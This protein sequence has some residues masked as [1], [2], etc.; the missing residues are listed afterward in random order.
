[1][2]L[3]WYFQFSM[4]QWYYAR[5]GERQGPVDR[6]TLESLARS[7]GLSADDLVWAEGMGDWQPA[8]M[9]DGLF[10]VVA[11]ADPA[12]PYASPASMSVGETGPRAPVG[13]L[14]VL[15]P[16]GRVNVG[17]P[18]QLA[19][20]IL[21]KDFGMIFVA[22]LVYYA[23][24]MGM[25]FLFQM[26]QSVIQFAT[27]GTM[28]SQ[29]PTDGMEAM[30]ASAPLLGFMVFSNIVQQVIGIYL[31]LGLARV[32]MEVIE[33][34]P[35]RIGGLFG[36][37]RKLIGAII[38]SI[39][40]GL[41]VIALPVLAVIPAIFFGVGGN[42]EMMIVLLVLAGLL[43]IFPGIYLAIRFGYFQVIMVDQEMGVMDALRESSRITRGNKWALFAL[44]VVLVL[45]TVAGILALCVGLIFTAPLTTLAGFVAYKWMVHGP[46]PLWDI[47]RPKLPGM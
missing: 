36:E 27:M 25:S 8:R 41:M 38:G 32:G 24:I 6:E 18:I 4:S 11:T 12:N 43:A 42:E 29:G 3:V 40:L 2:E 23:V 28:E 13:G 35:V 21:K 14:E 5:G 19:F 37:G 44:G 22:G 26:I 46:E 20:E 17:G 1:M 16:P 45:I 30:M 39:L 9:V 15:D 10:G 34:K 47:H 33:G 31:G 7:G